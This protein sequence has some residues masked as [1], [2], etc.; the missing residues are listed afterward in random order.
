MHTKIENNRLYF[1]QL[2]INTRSAS[3]RVQGSH[4]NLGP[5][6]F[7]YDCALLGMVGCVTYGRAQQAQE[8][9]GLSG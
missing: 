8:R 9:Q 1:V 5:K 6:L 2:F 4:I 7:P 3:E